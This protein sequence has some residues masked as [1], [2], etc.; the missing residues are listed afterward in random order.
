MRSLMTGYGTANSRSSS[1][2]PVL[3]AHATLILLL[4]PLRSPGLSLCSLNA[5]SQAIL[6]PFPMGNRIPNPNKSYIFISSI[7]LDV[8]IW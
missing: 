2:T 6:L 1:F 7:Q 8:S 3:R 4:L 5:P